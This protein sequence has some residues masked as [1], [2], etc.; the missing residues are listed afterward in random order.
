VNATGTVVVA[1]RNRAGLVVDTVG[2]LLADADDWPVIVVDDASDDDTSQRLD[3]CFGGSITIIRLERNARAAARNEGVRAATTELVAFADDDS[4]WAPG[5]LCRAADVF[6]ADERVGLVAATVIMEPKH[7]PAPIVEAYRESA[8]PA[9]AHGPSV[10]GFLACG[11]IV[12]R[13]AY[14]DV[15][16]FHPLL[17]IGGEEALLAMDLRA[18]G[19][20]LVHVPDVLA[21]HQSANTGR[22]GRAATVIYN[23]LV[24]QWLR[25]PVRTAV[26]STLRTVRAAV[27]DTESRRALRRLLAQAP[28]LLHDRRPLPDDVEEQ[29]EQLA[30]QPAG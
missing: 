24:V 1:T 27:D 20:T 22:E 23:E 29:V 4:W 2:R 25:R 13:A 9:T 15:G 5:S 18:A 30:V 21:H 11:A 10:L 26:A 6:A 17:G 8:L 3:C 7:V 12:R 16:G 14:L 19:W 28:L